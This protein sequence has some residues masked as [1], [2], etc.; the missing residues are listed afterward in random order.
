MCKRYFSKRDF[1]ILFS[2]SFIEM[3]NTVLTEYTSKYVLWQLATVAF[4]FL[5][6]VI[7]VSVYRKSSY[8]ILYCFEFILLRIISFSKTIGLLI[9][10]FYNVEEFVFI[11][12]IVFY[13]TSILYLLILSVA[14]LRFM[15]KE[16][17]GRF[18]NEHRGR[19]ETTENG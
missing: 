17:I 16:R 5:L 12:Y 10:A 7:F 2:L 4:Q 3:F 14:L 6:M 15:R 9:V 19:F 18:A 11:N 1:L 13:I 8:S